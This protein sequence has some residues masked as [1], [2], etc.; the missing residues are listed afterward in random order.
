MSLIAVYDR[1]KLKYIARESSVCRPFLGI[2]AFGC[3]GPSGIA[4]FP[5]IL[6]T[7]CLGRLWPRPAPNESW[8]L[9]HFGDGGMVDHR[10]LV[11]W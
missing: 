9:K 10:W 7:M 4:F 6:S 11:K 1:S 8:F 2:M 5:K 3:P